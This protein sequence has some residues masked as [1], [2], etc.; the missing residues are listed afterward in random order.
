MS[1]KK[2]KKG[3]GVATVLALFIEMLV[4]AA[5]AETTACSAAAKV[6]EKERDTLKAQQKEGKKVNGQL[7]QRSP[8]GMTVEQCQE[9]IDWCNGRAPHVEKLCED[10]GQAL[11]DWIKSSA[12]SDV[13]T[14][15]ARAQGFTVRHSG[16]AA[17]FYSDEGRAAFSQALGCL[18]GQQAAA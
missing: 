13:G 6:H 4:G 10:V 9:R 8:E 11:K 17:E 16:R 5:S 1:T 12:I 3:G 18:R 14:L 15:Y 2:S 7:I